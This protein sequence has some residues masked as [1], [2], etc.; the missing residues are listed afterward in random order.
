MP[1]RACAALPRVRTGRVTQE[2]GGRYDPVGLPADRR[3]L[4]P[5]DVAV[6]A[7]ADPAA[8]PD[9]GWP[10]EPVGLG[11]GQ[12][13]LGARG[14]RAPQV[15]EPVVVVPVRPQHHELPPGEE[16]WRAVTGSLLA[17]GQAC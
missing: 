2:P 5:V 13:L 4:V 14:R 16:R 12:L 15:R 6:Q 17:T 1:V 11:S 9:V 8:V 10:E 3:Y 7:H